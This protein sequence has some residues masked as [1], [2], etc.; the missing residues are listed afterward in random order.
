MNRTQRSRHTQS[1]C[2]REWIFRSRWKTQ[3]QCMQTR[4][5][6]SFSWSGSGWAKNGWLCSWSGIKK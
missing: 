3:T 1:K 2:W 6:F 5:G 4:L